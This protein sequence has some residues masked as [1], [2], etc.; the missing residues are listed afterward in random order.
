MGCSGS[1]S[2]AEVAGRASG[3]PVA[4]E[5]KVE[6]A[7][8][9]GRGAATAFASLAADNEKAAPSAAVADRSAVAERG[10]VD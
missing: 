7:A 10:M 3:Y 1:E 4:E 9:G 6:V 5:E 2:T 8:V